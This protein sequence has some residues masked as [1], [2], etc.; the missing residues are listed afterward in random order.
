MLP[1]T[2]LLHGELQMTFRRRQCTVHTDDVSDTR[3]LGSRLRTA[4]KHLSGLD[5]VL[6]LHYVQGV[7]ALP[8]ALQCL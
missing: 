3:V 4:L 7:P 8:P 1:S 5:F 2:L 6:R